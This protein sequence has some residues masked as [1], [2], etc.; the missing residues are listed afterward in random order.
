MRSAQAQKCHSVLSL[1]TFV[2]LKAHRLQTGI[3]GYAAKADFIR[4]AI[5][6]YLQNPTIVLQPTA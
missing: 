2:R 1:R 5:R 3:S 4:E 6:L